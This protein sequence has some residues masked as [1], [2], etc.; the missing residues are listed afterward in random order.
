M[1]SYTESKG[2]PSSS[3]ICNDKQK[4][5]INLQ[6][7]LCIYFTS[8]TFLDSFIKF[9]FSFTMSIVSTITNTMFH[10]HNLQNDRRI[11]YCN[12][13]FPLTTYFTTNNYD[14]TSAW[15]SFTFFTSFFPDLFSYICLE[16][17]GFIRYQTFELIPIFI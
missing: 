17:Y 5:Y 9:D 1:R 2:K 12:K 4:F 6:K 16:F 14:S 15:T 10:Q 8:Y 3:A 11:V 13:Q 7:W